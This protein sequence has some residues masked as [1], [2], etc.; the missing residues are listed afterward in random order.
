MPRPPSLYFQTLRRG[1]AQ[2]DFSPRDVV[3]EVLERIETRGD[4]AVWIHRLS[5]EE[6]LG[7]ADRIQI[8]K[9][10]G[11]SLPLYGIPFA[12][13]DNIDLAD[14]PTT[15]ACP[16]FSYRPDVSATAVQKLIEAGA[17]P[18]GKT[19]LDQFATGL[20]GVRSPYGAPRC[21]FNSRYISG[22]SSSGSAV[23]VAADLVGF[24]LGTD[25]AGSGRVPAA[26]NNL[27]GLKPTR[28][29]VSIK[30]VVPACR[31]LDCVSVFARTTT[32]VGE[33]LRV[34]EGV[35]PGDAWSRAV[36]PGTSASLPSSFRFGVPRPEQLK[37][38]GDQEAADLYAR[39]V[40]R[41][42]K[43]GGQ[44]V[45][46]DFGP[47]LKTARLL[48]HGPWV[49]ERMAAISDFYAQHAEAMDPTVRKIISGAEKMTA[50]E[51]FQGIYQLQE[52]RRQAAAVW[53]DVDLLA[54]PTAGTIYT[55]E[56]IQSDPIGRNT[57]LGYYTNFM[58]LLD[59]AGLALPAGFRPNG[60]PFGITLA[61]PAFTDEMLC[62][63]GGRWEEQGANL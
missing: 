11:K 40:S 14:Q 57:D 50:V 1:Y 51:T 59:L 2:G 55:V 28:G 36:P 8:W 17:I 49:A 52:L 22:G 27:V 41:L 61:A 44:K 60:L 43:L 18:V 32:E 29:R 5:R 19:N 53:N 30:G 6:I 48:Y 3:E 25:T 7:H 34:M 38:F 45:I 24:S 31:S 46:F 54:L 35:D 56:E 16:A 26:F 63:V 23:A 9:R 13:K 15:A 37:F 33:V 42:Q 21:V 20:V 4:D 10:E 58:N 39:A 47:F 62:G 12:I